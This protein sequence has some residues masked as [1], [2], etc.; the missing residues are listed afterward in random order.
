MEEMWNLESG[1]GVRSE[2]SV[3]MVVGYVI[4]QWGEVRK[5]GCWVD[6]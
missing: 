3:E 2:E 5:V 1:C 4:L 6:G